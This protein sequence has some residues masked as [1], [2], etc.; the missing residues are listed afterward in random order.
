MTG[1]A[2]PHVFRPAR[3][4]AV[5]I[6]TRIVRTA[7]GTK[8]TPGGMVSDDLIAYHLARADADIGLTILEL[9]PVH[10][11]SPS[12]GI[13]IWDDAALPGLRRLADALRPFPMKVF[14]QLAHVGHG[15]VF[16]DGRRPWGPS[17]VRS[18]QR[19][20]ALVPNPMT[21]EQISEIVA[22]FADGARR[23]VEAGLDGVEV[24]AAHGHLLGQFLSP[25][26][27]HRRDAY[28][29]PI[30]NRAR[31]LLETMA[32]AKAAVGDAAPVGV[33]LSADELAVGG[34]AGADVAAV[35]RLLE[36]AGV[37]DFVDLSI[38]S[39][40]SYHRVIGGMDEPPGY[41]LAHSLPIARQ[42][43]VPSIVVG[44]ITTLAHAEE[45]LASGDT[46]LVSM[47]RATIADPLIVRKSRLGRAGRARPCIGCNQGCV[48]GND[49]GSHIGCVVNPSVGVERTISDEPA[50]AAVTKRVV[51]IGG[52][53]AGMEAARVAA[54]R[55][56]T[57]TL[58]ERR[59]VLGGQL[60][61]A[62]RLPYRHDIGQIVGWLAA[63]LK[64]LGVE[65]RLGVEASP[66]EVER[67]APDDVVV[68]TGSAPRTD[69]A[70]TSA[71]LVGPIPGSD[72]PH[73]RT[74][75]QALDGA[76]PPGGSV[77]VVDD[78]GH[79]EGVGVAEWLLAEG[80]G[81]VTLVTS[82]ARLAVLMEPARTVGA[83]KTRLGRRPG[84]TF[85]PDATLCRIDPASVT[86]RP[87][88]G[89]ADRT[90]DADAVV[91]VLSNQPVVPHVRGDRA[92]WTEHIVGDAGG[93]RFLQ[94]AIDE[95]HRAALRIG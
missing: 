60:A 94:V 51:V 22:A 21:S 16:A 70:L 25:L 64:Q 8:L 81:R 32:A 62:R 38:G 20:T 89:G 39:A 35:V 10:R 40:F 86:V 80:A 74:T 73:V 92:A 9:A 34:M 61:Y 47:V 78:V 11:S 6:P 57:V 31:F 66:A 28:G 12:G 77:V 90:I 45:I 76:P 15:A 82:R 18:P 58:I 53:P 65:V 27:N 4:G 87:V 29:G 84:F 69:A 49:G 42:T 50:P 36:D 54:Q 91:L 59:P 33:R 13:R 24:H 67:L 88:F 46:D 79:Y 75:W 93:A 3:I 14:A 48:G 68:A 17:A 72:L 26:T 63:E 37:V 41:Q 23:A 55:G 44:R 71:P 19:D 95:G 52:G 1:T 85:L 56:H 30:D 43:R 2:Y 7:H 5:E 83:L